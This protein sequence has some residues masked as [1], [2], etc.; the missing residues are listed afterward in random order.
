MREGV[1]REHY[2]D[3]DGQRRD[4]HMYRMFELEWRDHRQFLWLAVWH[5]GLSGRSSGDEP[6]C[7]AVERL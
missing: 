5:A 1:L 3:S 6:H 4:I 2:V 7:V